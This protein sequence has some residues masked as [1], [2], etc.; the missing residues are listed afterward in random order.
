MFKH[1]K[2]RRAVGGSKERN[3]QIRDLIVPDAWHVACRMQDLGM[4]RDAKVVLECWTLCIDMWRHLQEQA[5][6]TCT[7]ANERRMDK[8]MNRLKKAR[9]K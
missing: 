4:K 6:S 1:P 3:V 5:Y 8:E 9:G 7:V 2:I